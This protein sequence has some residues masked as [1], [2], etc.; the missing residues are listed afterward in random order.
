MAGERVVAASAVCA[1]SAEQLWRLLSD[2]KR[3]VEWANATR[4]VL[5]SDDPLQIGGVYVERNRLLGTTV[6]SRSK[7]RKSRGGCSIA[8]RAPG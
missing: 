1:G 8:P 4:A 5:R 6:T 7:R 2:P 3:F